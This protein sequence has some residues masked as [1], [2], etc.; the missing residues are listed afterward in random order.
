[1]ENEVLVAQDLKSRLLLMGYP[2]SGLALDGDEAEAMAMATKPEL[3]LMDINLGRGRNGI[4]T[5]LAIRAKLDVPVIYI[6]ANSDDQTIHRAAQSDPFGFI[7]KPFEDRALESAIQLGV[8]KHEMECRLRASE[9]RFVNTLTSIADGVIALRADGRVEFMNPSAERTTGWTLSEAYGRRLAEVFPL[10]EDGQDLSDAR[11]F[12]LFGTG[13]V[14]GQS[15]TAL[16]R[17]RSGETVP[18][19]YRAAHMQMDQATT[20]GTVISFSDITA[21]RAAE[22]NIRTTQAKLQTAHQSLARKHEELQNL[23]HIVSHELKTPLTSA[24]EF[25]SLVLEGLA[26]PVNDTQLEYLQIAQ[27]S[28]DQMRTCI[29]DMLD[30]TRLETGKLRIELQQSSPVQLVERTVL[31]FQPVAQQKRIDLQAQIGTAIPEILMDE[32]RLAQVLRNLISNALKFT[33]EGGRITVA[34]NAVATPVFAVQLTVS[35]TGRGIPR[36][37]LGRIFDRLYQVREDDTHSRMGLGLGLFICHE[38]VQ[39]HQGRIAVQSEVGKGS[40]FQVTLP[41]APVAPVAPLETT[42][43]ASCRQA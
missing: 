28:C 6:T 9:H 10:L 38:L 36:E 3:I 33:P 41:A 21:R 27:E 20:E 18:V 24:R 4:E 14:S 1:M 23:Y 39:M 43:M 31:M 8:A 15:H 2:V 42:V 25:V 34:L 17:C 7:L 30:V 19:E 16:L 13:V 5:A 40:A 11:L 37:H 22:E 32:T 29:N 35:D 12:Y 26:G